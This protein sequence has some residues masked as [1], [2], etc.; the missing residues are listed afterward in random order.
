MQASGTVHWQSVICVHGVQAKHTMPEEQH[1][2]GKK[3]HFLHSLCA[4][5][6]SACCSRRELLKP[7]TPPQVCIVHL[8]Q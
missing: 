7:L 6:A 4:G 1:L 3:G 2:D 5:R 8:P